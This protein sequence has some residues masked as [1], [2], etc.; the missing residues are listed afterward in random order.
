MGVLSAVLSPGS[1]DVEENPRGCWGD[2]CKESHGGV[3]PGT[4]AD[5]WPLSTPCWGELV[6]GMR[7]NLSAWR[8]QE[9]LWVFPSSHQAPGTAPVPWV[10]VRRHWWWWDSCVFMERSYYGTVTRRTFTNA[11]IMVNKTALGFFLESKLASWKSHISLA[12]HE[13]ETRT[14]NATELWLYHR[15]LT[16][17]IVYTGKV[18]IHNPTNHTYTQYMTIISKIDCLVFY[19]LLDERECYRVGGWRIKFSFNKTKVI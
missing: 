4:S 7:V 6:P 2:S 9:S 5:K 8:I 19:S 1:G 10:Q 3:H 17:I 16:I 14:T 12:N 13:V 11:H 18:K 15:T